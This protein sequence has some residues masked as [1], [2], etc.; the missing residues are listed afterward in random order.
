MNGIV[1]NYHKCRFI[2]RGKHFSFYRK[3]QLRRHLRI[4]FVVRPAASP[5]LWM[6]VN[7]KKNSK[8][9]FLQTI[10]I[11]FSHKRLF[12]SSVFYFISLYCI[13]P[14]PPLPSVS[15]FSTSI[16]YL[17]HFHFLYSARS[18]YFAYAL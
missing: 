6:R 10:S 14:P 15:H 3:L 12:Y 18:L 17:F 1:A 11:I 7:Y 2:G 13:Y 8:Y 5:F 4:R 9:I 16:S